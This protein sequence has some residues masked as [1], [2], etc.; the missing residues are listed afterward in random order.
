MLQD[1]ARE[2]QKHSSIAKKYTDCFVVTPSMHQSKNAH[3]DRLLNQ[4]GEGS[5]A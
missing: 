3:I 2:T 1:H 5:E 4:V